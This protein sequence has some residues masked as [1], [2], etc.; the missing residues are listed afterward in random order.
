M[1]ELPH[2]HAND[3]KLAD[4]LYAL[5]DPVRL[6]IVK[7]LA[8]NGEQTCGNIS[9]PVSKS[10]ASH[11]FR[12]LREAGI[13]RMRAS[14]PSYLNSLRRDELDSRFPGLLNLIIASI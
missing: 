13:I 5:G 9:A 3:L 2:P 1:R 4:V 8:K 6:G 10:T 11:H 14:G 7:C 12:I